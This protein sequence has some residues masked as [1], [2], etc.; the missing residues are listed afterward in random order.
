MRYLTLLLL[1]IISLNLQ[2]Q[3]L[4][5]EI[6]FIYTKAKYLIET[7]RTEDAVKEL[8]KI[9]KKDAYYEDALLLRAEAKYQLGAYAG[10]KKDLLQFI[11][12]KGIT[13]R[14]AK[15]YGLTDFQGGNSDAALNS[16]STALKTITDD[17][18]LYEVRAQIYE[19]NNQLLKACEDF[20]AA[21]KLGSNIGMRKS[22][23]LCGEDFTKEKPK[24]KRNSRKDSKIDV[25]KEDSKVI[26]KNKNS[27][28]SRERREEQKEKES[29]SEEENEEERNEE[30]ENEE[31]QK[32]TESVEDETE[33][34]YID[35]DD[36]EEMKDKEQ[37]D[38]N[39]VNEIVV[40]E[41]LTLV[42]SGDGLGSREIVDKPNI[43][44]LSDDTGDVAINVCVSRAGRV[45]AAEFDNINSTIKKQSLVSLALRKSKD[46]WFEKNG[47]KEQCGTI[48]FK[49]K[50]I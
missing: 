13:A 17:K 25:S 37:N 30:E 7:N 24:R 40:D 48:V 38:M 34:D 14:V 10:V 27:K 4:D 3:S 19:S 18:K 12:K 29:H 43:L 44:I 49:I 45:T 2:S 32:E 42:I 31:E 50:G 47:T 21:G 36:E 20:K 6:G 46:F 23:S 15:L 9:I 16:L 22:K 39:A 11:D 33:E 1:S 41:D 8:N 28:T 26:R 5:E 35:N